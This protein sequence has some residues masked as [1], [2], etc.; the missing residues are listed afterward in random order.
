L[1]NKHDGVLD[2]GRMMDNFQKH[3]IC[4]NVP[5]SQAFFSGAVL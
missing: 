5:L 3:N 2:K 1:K 4:I